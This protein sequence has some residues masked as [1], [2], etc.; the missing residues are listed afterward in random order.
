MNSIVVRYDYIIYDMI[1]IYKLSG[2]N[3]YE[4]CIGIAKLVQSSH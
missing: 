1:Y 2:P 4:L 3:T